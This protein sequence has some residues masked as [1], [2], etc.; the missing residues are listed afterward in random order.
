[1]RAKIARIYF[2]IFVKIHQLVDI[3]F[4]YVYKIKKRKKMYTTL[5]DYVNIILTCGVCLAKRSVIKKE[6]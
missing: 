5:P 2:T 6:D 4:S 1:M 3:K